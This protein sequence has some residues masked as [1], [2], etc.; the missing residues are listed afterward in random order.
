MLWNLSGVDLTRDGWSD[1]RVRS[2]VATHAISLIRRRVGVFELLISMSG[3]S[4]MRAR[5][6]FDRW[7]LGN[8]YLKAGHVAKIS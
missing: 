7:R 8:A 2:F 3:P 5:E 6:R 1:Q 4:L